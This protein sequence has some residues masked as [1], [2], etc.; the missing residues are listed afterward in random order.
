MIQT[1]RQ[2]GSVF[3]ASVEGSA[4]FKE[5]L[6]APREALTKAGCAKCT[7]GVKGK[8]W[9]RVKKALSNL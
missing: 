8:K 3:Q 5:A 7:E 6:L 2:T 1:N 4:T 9:L